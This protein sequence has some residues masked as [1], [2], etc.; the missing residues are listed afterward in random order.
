[1]F[2][3]IIILAS[4]PNRHVTMGKNDRLSVITHWIAEL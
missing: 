2:V 4:M 3:F 1:M